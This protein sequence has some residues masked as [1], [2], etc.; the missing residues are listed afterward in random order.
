MT[1][2]FKPQFL[3]ILQG[4]SK[5]VTALSAADIW[6]QTRDELREQMAPV[7]PFETQLVDH[8]AFTLWR[9][10]RLADH[11]VEQMS[12]SGKAL[13]TDKACRYE[14]HLQRS[15]IASTAT[16]ERMQRGRM[17]HAGLP[18]R[19]LERLPE[20]VDDDAEDQE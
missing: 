2:E 15:L 3:E 11:G 5:D 14:A 8:I 20:A 13:G 9:L 7:G 12:K 16:L 19:R 17:Q 18:G 6:Q 10:Q 4:R 1:T